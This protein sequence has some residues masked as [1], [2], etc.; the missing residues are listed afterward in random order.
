V[1]ASV[2]ARASRVASGRPVLDSKTVSEPCR[3]SRPRAGFRGR[4]LI[5]LTLRRSSSFS[6]PEMRKMP[7]PSPRSMCA[8][9]GAMAAPRDTMA[10]EA[11]I[12]SATRAGSTAMISSRLKCLDTR[13]LADTGQR[14]EQ[15]HRL[16]APRD[17]ELEDKMADPKLGRTLE[18]RDHLLAN[19]TEGGA[20]CRRELGALPALLRR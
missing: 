4:T 1:R 3:R 18:I 8:R 11:A 15:R 19:A 9:T 17:G 7:A 20:A 2:A 16:F 6:A 10:S 13:F 12:A 5:T 14:F